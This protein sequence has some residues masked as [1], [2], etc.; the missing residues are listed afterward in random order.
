M[1]ALYLLAL[2][3]VAKTTGDR[4]SYGFRP[5][6]STTD[7]IVQCHVLLG[8]SFSAQWVFEADIRGC[9]DHIDHQW[10]IDN[11]PMDKGVLRKWLKAGS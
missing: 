4:N 11:V 7:A 2:L 8:R 10:L 6:R 9:F 5:G 1:Q 3:P